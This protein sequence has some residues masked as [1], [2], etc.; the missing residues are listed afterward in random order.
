MSRIAALALAALVLSA[1]PGSGQGGPPAGILFRDV[2][3]THL[4][5]EVLGGRSMD[6][7][8]W[9]VDGDD[10]LDLVIAVEF[11]P[12]LL[13]IND[14]H[15]VFADESSARLPRTFRDSEDIAIA[16]FDGNLAPDIVIV[17]ED[18]AVNEL[19]LNDGDG[20]F[21][22]ASDRIPLTGISNA[23]VTT[24]LDGDGSPDLLIGNRGQNF[25]LLNDGSGFFVDAT[26]ARLPS[27]GRITQDLELG[28][29]DGDH[30]LDLLVANENG[31]RLLL[32]DGAGFFTDVTPG[33]LPAS[34]GGEETREADLGDIDGDGDLDIHF[35]NVDFFQG[36]PRQDRLLVNDGAGFFTDV[37]FL[38]PP[39]ARH[40]VD[41]DFVDLDGDGD[42]DLVLA[43]TA[44]Q[45]VILLNDRP[46]ILDS[47]SALIPEPP[48][49]TGFD[50]EVADF[51]GDGLPDIYVA[52]WTGQ[53]DLLLGVERGTVWPIL[54]GREP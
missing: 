51:D 17:S 37:S 28:D 19:Y 22:D 8:P 2:S 38:L 54:P 7:E 6:A 10:D 52:D 13:L 12:N 34:P 18:D 46:R 21:V 39:P 35:A 16:D 9:D 50:V 41:V 30:D 47:T 14:G 49:G 20:F 3:E 15:G 43:E 32:N 26:D 27:D 42:Q 23:V 48:P 4:P 40:S 31:N 53:D 45:V 5:V 36:L 44:R 33:R 24:D 11:G 29:V 1:P 25:A